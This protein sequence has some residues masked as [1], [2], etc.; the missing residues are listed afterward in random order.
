MI[1]NEL[2][3]RA[4][5]TDVANAVLDGT[6]AVM[7]S[8]ETAKGRHPAT[9]VTTMSRIA[10][11]AETLLATRTELPLG[12]TTRSTATELTVA[13]TRAA[14][15]TAERIEAKLLVLSTRSGKTAAALSELRSRV[16]ILALTDTAQ[17]AS[18]L[19]T[20]VGCRGGGDE[21]GGDVVA[22][23]GAVR[24]GVERAAG[25][26]EARRPLR[27]D[28]YDRLVTGGEGSAA[29]A[30]GEVGVDQQPACRRYA[31]DYA[32]QQRNPVS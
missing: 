5:A 27:T 9:V 21:S 29:G 4:E 22:T 2:P 26:L 10:R 1:Q 7:L 15:Q 32:A 24:S 3:T 17:T 11:E 25:A 12:L 30:G 28:R 13:I 23:D 16:P 8:G 14:I 18:L 6:D 20:H 19:A 31:L